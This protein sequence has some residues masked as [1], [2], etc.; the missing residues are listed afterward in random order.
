MT[1]D[2]CPYEYDTRAYIHDALDE[3]DTEDDVGDDEQRLS[4]DVG[5]NLNALLQRLQSLMKHKAE[6]YQDGP[7][8]A[9]PVPAKT[10]L[11]FAGDVPGDVKLSGST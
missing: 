4:D 9:S 10:R 3:E 6:M 11:T 2:D 8:R 7:T 1:A 5:V